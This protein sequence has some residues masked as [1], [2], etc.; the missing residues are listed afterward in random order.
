MQPK[1]ITKLDDLV[2]YIS[3]YLVPLVEDAVE[4]CNRA[5][6]DDEYNDNWTFGTQLWRNL[7]N[8]IYEAA[9]SDDN[10]IEICHGDHMYAFRIGP[11]ML[12]HHRV[13]RIT[14]IPRSAKAA[15]STADAVQL[16]L[17]D[18]EI[19]RTDLNNIILAIAAEPGVGLS[20]IFIGKLEKVPSSSQYRWAVRVPVL[21][22]EEVTD[23]RVD[24]E[25]E[26]VPVVSYQPEEE[27][28]G[29]LVGYLDKKAVLS[30]SGRSQ[31][32]D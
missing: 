11:A 8:R 28:P 5:Y 27:E 30:R 23:Q 3:E 32:N 17:F 15:K 2:P 10:P 19:Y 24:Y 25:V 4:T 18:E 26:Q 16:L 14:S 29:S 31:D 6:M 9:L 13:N 20:E 21:A 22:E 1:G 7:W 12:R